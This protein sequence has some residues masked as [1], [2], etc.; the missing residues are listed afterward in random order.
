VCVCVHLYISECVDVCRYTASR[1]FTV[2]TRAVSTQNDWGFAVSAWVD[3]D[4]IY[5]DGRTGVN[6]D[7]VV[8]RADFEML[9]IGVFPIS[10]RQELMGKRLF[11]LT[12]THVSILQL[13]R[14]RRGKQSCQMVQQRIL[15]K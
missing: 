6:K 5:V 3:G 15:G 14:K 9:R 1:C 4:D 10:G 13:P 8:A 7:S 2:E 12:S 11:I